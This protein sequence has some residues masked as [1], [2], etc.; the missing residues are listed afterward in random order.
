MSLIF[1]KG[2]FVPKCYMK[3]LIKRHIALKGVKER[4]RKVSLAK[5]KTF[6]LNPEIKELVV[7]YTTYKPVTPNNQV[8]AKLCSIDF[9]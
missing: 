3:S 9:A 7:F 5:T 2:R 4:Y 6:D 8:S 1:G